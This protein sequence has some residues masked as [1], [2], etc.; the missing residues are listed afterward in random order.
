MYVI[1]QT[2]V[3]N[4]LPPKVETH[5]IIENATR[6]EAGLYYCRASHFVGGVK[7]E[8][9]NTTIKI[10]RKFFALSTTKVIYGVGIP[11]KR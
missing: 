10:Y 4:A 5:L 8:R 11:K 7:E 3:P 9:A 2:V 1:T 6:H